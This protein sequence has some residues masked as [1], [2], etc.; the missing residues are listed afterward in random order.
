MKLI[1]HL[2]SDDD[3]NV[4]KHKYLSNAYHFL[5]SIHKS[6]NDFKCSIIHEILAARHQEKCPS[7]DIFKFYNS[8]LFIANCCS[9]LLNPNHEFALFWFER[10]YDCLMKLRV[11]ND[12]RVNERSLLD[13]NCR[14]GICHYHMY[15]FEA[16]FECL[17]K[18]L[19]SE[20]SRK[21][22]DIIEKSKYYYELCSKFIP[23]HLIDEK[24][25]SIHNWKKSEIIGEIFSI[26]D[27]FL[28][29]L[30]KYENQELTYIEIIRSFAE[31][32]KLKEY[33][34]YVIAK[35]IRS[36]GTIFFYELEPENAVHFYR[37]SIE[38]LE[39][40]PIFDFITV[41]KLKIELLDCIKDKNMNI[42]ELFKMV[43]FLLELIN[44]LE[45]QDQ[46]QEQINTDKCEILSVIYLHLAKI[47]NHL[48]KSELSELF[49]KKAHDFCLKCKNINHFNIYL[50]TKQIAKIN[51][52]NNSYD[53]ARYWFTKSINALNTFKN[54]L[55]FSEYKA[56]LNCEIG[57]FELHYA[58][59]IENAM[60]FFKIILNSVEF[61]KY[62]IFVKMSELY[63][64]V[65]LYNQQDYSG[66]IPYIESGL[67]Y[68]YQEEGISLSQKADASK[69]L[70]VCYMNIKNYE[71]AINAFKKACETFDSMDYKSDADNLSNDD[72]SLQIGVC[73]GEYFYIP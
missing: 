57:F 13:L 25:S 44:I 36:F 28:E 11:L 15:N 14:I 46:N 29:I 24:S 26:R 58:E 16:A 66:A 18:N 32:L 3:E 51:I 70:G 64:G 62:E 42:E 53:A 55:Q 27:E 38:L 52:K 72:I 31:R 43:P 7:F 20:I 17:E 50:A 61:Q 34:N 19:S 71:S 48:N 8:S 23:R 56:Q 49:Y 68:F 73:L 2:E 45:F 21:N 47:N 54:P 65:C 33:N 41:F 9:E 67:I 69:I 60:K 6:R 4:K 12:K 10:A 35:E 1:I 30:I 63:Y 39:S 22:I 40:V 59:S 5:G 37:F